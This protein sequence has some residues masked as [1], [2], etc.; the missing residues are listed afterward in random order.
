M[1]QFPDCHGLNPAHQLGQANPDAQG[2]FHDF[3]QGDPWL[4]RDN[5][6]P[7]GS[8]SPSGRPGYFEVGF[9]FLNLSLVA[10]CECEVRG[11]GIFTVHVRGAVSGVCDDFLFYGNV[12]P[13]RLDV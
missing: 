13:C 12:D 10:G 8:F 11:D 7:V 5:Y 9:Y 2:I 3:A 1:D 4:F 6:C